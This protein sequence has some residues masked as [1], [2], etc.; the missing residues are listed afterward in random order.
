MDS[1]ILKIALYCLAGGRKAKVKLGNLG[2]ICSSL[3][4]RLHLKLRDLSGNPKSKSSISYCL[5]I[6]MCNVRYCKFQ[7]SI[8][9]MIQK[10]SLY[11]LC[12]KSKI[13]DTDFHASRFYGEIEKLHFTYSV[14]PF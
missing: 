9:C 4:C 8:V 11:S 10:I 6:A 7:Y 14:Q 2:P 13:E 3:T 5:P 1:R 12:E